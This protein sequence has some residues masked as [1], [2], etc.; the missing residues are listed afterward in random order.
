MK[1][2]ILIYII[3]AA[4]LLSSCGGSVTAPSV[5]DGTTVTS[6][7]EVTTT[8]EITTAETT[9]AATTEPPI[10]LDPLD[11]ARRFVTVKGAY[12]QSVCVSDDFVF[13]S[14]STS[15][16]ADKN[17]YVI[18]KYDRFT[19]ELIAEGKTRLNHANGM[20]YNSKTDE[21]VVTGLDGNASSTSSVGDQDYSLFFLDPDTLDIKRTVCLRELIELI[22]PESTGI[23]GVAYDEKTDE[24]YVLTRY[25]KRYILRLSGDLELLWDFPIKEDLS[26]TRGD[27][28]CDGEYVYTVLWLNPS[29]KNVVDI[30]TRDGDFVERKEV[31]GLTHIEGL[32]RRNGRFYLCFIDFN[33]SPASA[34]VCEMDELENVK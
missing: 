25:P 14:H 13:I 18:Q 15:F 4:L 17:D 27:I 20:A 7:P 26:G 8:A 21:I 33:V 3:L 22:L 23:S 12:T 24:Y 34:V 5:T 1:K 29:I 10:I 11:G 19:G 30:Y 32:D 6:A 31:N 28:C 16:G 9:T 2:T